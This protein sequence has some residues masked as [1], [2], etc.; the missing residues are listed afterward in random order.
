METFLKNLIFGNFRRKTLSL[1]AAI[2]IWLHVSSSI[3]TTR[4]FSRILVH[5]INI[6]A[7]KT[8]RGL[9]PDGYLE[10]RLSVTLTGSKDVLDRTVPEDFEVRIDASDKGDEWVAQLTKTDLVP[11]NTDIQFAN[12]VTQVSYSPPLVIHLCD[13]ATEKIPIYVLSPQGDAP[14]GYEFHGVWPR[15]LYQTV[16]GPKEDVKRLQERGLE[17]NI[18]MS[19]IER[20]VLDNLRIQQA[21]D[22]EFEDEVSYFIPDVYKK[23]KIPFLN[24]AS[25]MINSPEARQLRIDFLHKEMLALNSA[26][27]VRLFY[28]IKTAE[29]LNPEKLFLCE[30][31]LLKKKGGVFYIERPLMVSAVS[32]LFLEIIRENIEI[33][34]IP[35]IREGVVTFDWNI[36]LVGSSQLEENYITRTLSNEFDGD[37]EIGG[38]KAFRQHLKQREAYL[39]SQ[40]RE[41]LKAL[42]LFAGPTVSFELTITSDNEGAVSIKEGVT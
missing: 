7:N 11:Q 15:R 34:I 20:E 27:S 22:G 6:P 16:T 21:H 3:S 36:Q 13:S 26:I 40:F 10:K 41:Y 39:R 2:V 29:R 1:L 35:A 18:D 14:E 37:C 8:V 4:T 28:P 12:A 30:G 17:L 38:I 42:S 19:R 24:D 25:Q 9:L 31:G 23:I 32:R 33:E 5:I